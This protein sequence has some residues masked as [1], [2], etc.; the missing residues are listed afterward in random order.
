[1]LMKTAQYQSMSGKNTF[2]LSQGRTTR[3]LT[4]PK[5]TREVPKKIFREKKPKIHLGITWHEELIDKPH[6]IRTHA[7]FA[8]KV[9]GGDA[10]TKKSNTQNYIKHYKRNCFPQSRCKSEVL[11][12]E[13]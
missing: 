3:Q 8:P 12:H 2:Q 7:H 1:M 13:S 6:P 9:C 11:Y 5:A 4:W 10:E